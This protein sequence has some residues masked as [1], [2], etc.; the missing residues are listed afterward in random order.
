MQ[1]LI[2]MSLFVSSL[3]WS[4]TDYSKCSN[5]LKPSFEELGYGGFTGGIGSPNSGMYGGGPLGYLPFEIDDKGK[6]TPHDD[7]KSYMASDNGDETIM[8]EM[9]SFIPVSDPNKKTN[10]YKQNMRQVSV[11][12]KRNGSGEIQE[13]VYDQNYTQAELTAMHAQLQEFYQQSKPEEQRKQNDEWAK[14]NGQEGFQVPFFTQSATTVKF[15]IKNGQCVPMEVKNESLLEPKVDGSTYETTQMN[16]PLCKD[17]RDFLNENPEAAACMKSD[18]NKKM[19]DIFS[20]YTP[21]GFGM[22]GGSIGIGV[23]FPGGGINGGYGMG[24]FGMPMWG[25]SIENYLMAN[26]NP[27]WIPEGER[28]AYF[29]RFGSSPV[30]TGNML[31]QQCIDNGLSPILEDESIWV[32]NTV[33]N[34]NGDNSDVPGSVGSDGAE[35]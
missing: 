35:N 34:A 13:I 25:M 23:G 29:A 10:P 3:A 16:T 6:I 31:Y 4:A 32:E 33:T 24:G 7:V 17:I 26:Q 22:P 15:D 2:V 30:I 11:E 27:E 14:Q 8:F 5:Y 20:K 12:I 18:L 9:P 1:K 28:E 19:G 21:E